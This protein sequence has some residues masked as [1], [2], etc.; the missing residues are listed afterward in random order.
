MMLRARSILMMMMAVGAL[1]ACGGGEEGAEPGMDAEIAETPAGGMEGMQGREGMAGI[2]MDGGM[3]GQMQAHMR[4][5]EGMSG[6]SMMQMMPQHRKMVANMIA[7][8]NREMRDMNMT[9]DPEW[10]STIEALRQD[11]FQIP[12]MSAA[13][14]EAFM[15]EHRA[16]VMRLMEMHQQMMPEMSM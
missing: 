3:M 8:M 1:A 5:M 11:L 13:E 9:T 7:Q 2:Q 15:P 10:N 12:E 4:M 14:T 6:D 16:R